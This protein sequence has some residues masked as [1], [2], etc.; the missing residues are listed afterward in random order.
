MMTVEGSRAPQVS[1]YH[2]CHRLISQLGEKTSGK[3]FL[4]SLALKIETYLKQ[5]CGHLHA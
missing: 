1:G 5:D 3:N 2:R 4:K